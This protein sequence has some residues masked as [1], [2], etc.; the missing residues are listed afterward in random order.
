MAVPAWSPIV[1]RARER[2]KGETR[3]HQKRKEQDCGS[4]RQPHHVQVDNKRPEKHVN[5]A[6]NMLYIPWMVILGGH[7]IQTTSFENFDF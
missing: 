1:R 4:A 6:Y 2:E 7:N 5:T 3:A